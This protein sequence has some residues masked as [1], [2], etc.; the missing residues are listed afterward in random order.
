[1]RGPKDLETTCIQPDV[2]STGGSKK[3]GSPRFTQAKEQ[4]KGNI[5]NLEKGMNLNLTGNS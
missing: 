2:K 3:E 4:R 5:Q 1:M